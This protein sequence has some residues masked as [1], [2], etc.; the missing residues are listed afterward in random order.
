MIHNRHKKSLQTRKLSHE[1]GSGRAGDRSG[2][3]GQPEE[4]VSFCAEDILDSG[5]SEEEIVH[6][7]GLFILL[8]WS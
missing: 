1:A 2:A 8:I 6:I 5:D 4:K 3:S 7:D